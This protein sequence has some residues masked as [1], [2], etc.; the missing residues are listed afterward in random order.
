M[1]PRRQHRKDRVNAAEIVDRLRREED[2]GFDFKGPAEF[3]GDFRA[4]LTVDIAA[5]ANTPGGGTVVIGVLRAE[6][7]WK[8]EGCNATQLASFDKTPV[9]QYVRNFLDPLPRFGIESVEV[10]GKKLV[11]VPVA[12]FEDVPTVVKKTI[13]TPKD[14]L[15]RE[16]DLLMRSEA[17]QSRVIQSA[18]EMRQLL[19]RAL[20]RK[21]ENLLAEIRAVVTGVGPRQ[22]ERTPVELFEG[23]VPSWP[24]EVAAFDAKFAVYARWEVAILLDPPP[25][26][27]EPMLLPDVL[28]KAQVSFRG[29]NFPHTD[30]RTGPYFGMGY[31][32][33]R[34]DW[35]EHQEV[36]LLSE[37]G[38][39]GF[40][41][42]VWSD[43]RQPEDGS[44]NPEIAGRLLNAIG[45]LWSLTEFFRFAL[46]LAEGFGS[47]RAWVSVRLKGIR[48]RSLAPPNPMWTGDSESR[49][50][51]VPL[52]GL[53]AVADLKSS[54][55]EK[56]RGW[57][58]KVF[59]V[60]QW[61]DADDRQ[62]AAE[63]EKL[64]ERRW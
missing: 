46:N 16:G 40:A 56:A 27:L 49:S 28:R 8:V 47:E 22:L 52:D 54:W 12:E 4:G 48:G 6:G 43:L 7:V 35:R 51:E 57:A 21:S 30:G 38:A 14:T 58:E 32:E 20:S 50:G 55:K 34:T 41:G 25:A 62:L 39:F 44:D 63:Q 45:I 9:T 59:T 31:V 53:F 33:V 3:S 60:F 42:V 26:P 18:D 17:A 19:G 1:G 24:G 10:D 2:R 29:W 61:P 64:I 36:A 5:M 23:Q 11:V 37:R 13:Q 15:A